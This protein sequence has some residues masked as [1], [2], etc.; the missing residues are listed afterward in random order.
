MR[1]LKKVL[2]KFDFI[3]QVYSFLFRVQQICKRTKTG[4]INKVKLLY[5]LRFMYLKGNSK[6]NIYENQIN[7]MIKK[8]RK[9]E[10]KIEKKS[11]FFGDPKY[12]YVSSVRGKDYKKIERWGNLTPDYDLFISNGIDY[13]K[14]LT[15]E[16]NYFKK[17][18]GTLYSEIDRKRPEVLKKLKKELVKTP[19]NIFLKKQ[20]LFLET[21]ILKG[22]TSFLES[23]Q[24]LFFIHQLLWIENNSLIGLGSLDQIL[25][26]YYIEDLKNEKI[27]R[28]DAKLYLKDFLNNIGK[29]L[30]FKSS[31]LLG[32]TGQAITVGGKKENE[33]SILILEAIEGLNIVSPKI[34]A[35]IGL[36]TSDEFYNKAMKVLK[37]KTGSPLFINEDL[38]IKGLEN[39]GYDTN[40]AN[41]F[42]TAA[43]WEPLIPGKSFDLNIGIIN[44][45][46][47]LEKILYSEDEKEI[48][49]DKLMNSYEIELRKLLKDQIEISNKTEFSPKILLSSLYEDALKK[50][51]DISQ[52]CL[53]YNSIGFLSVGFS[54]V[55]NA[56]YSLKELM[57]TQSKFQIIDKIRKNKIEDYF[58]EIKKFSKFGQDLDEVDEIAI[59]ISEVYYDELQK[60]STRFGSKFK[61]GLGSASGYID[62]KDMPKTNFDGRNHGETLSNNYS[63]Q[64]GT[65][66]DPVL[67]LNSLVKIDLKKMINGSI[68]DVTF[69]KNVIEKYPEKIKAYLNYF[70]SKHGQSVQFNFLDYKE[71][72]EA[73]KYPGRYSNLI[74]RVWGMSSYFVNL[75]KEF[76]D[77]IINRAREEK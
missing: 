38:T 28:G 44:F 2:K 40:D 32:D 18:V 16:E 41:E 56:I 53:K 25:Y 58:D 17:Q 77:Q 45:L 60:H 14:S 1:R 68:M 3:M 29:N 4:R 71:L 64:S 30:E 6:R 72:I 47:P 70:V 33:L 21:V 51:C 65:K 37:G 49:L 7:F 52:G 50:G 63:P 66:T 59:K 57:K 31:V 46:E 12:Y 76:Q 42:V 8:I 54:N 39:Y 22:A 73:Q 27:T 75:P 11:Y 36:N 10:F 19:K 67:T 62:L 69:N 13:Y 26:K 74:V 43:C 48:N 35:K 55:V 24:M 9:I 34:I 20:E 61:P 15:K 5:K 23:L